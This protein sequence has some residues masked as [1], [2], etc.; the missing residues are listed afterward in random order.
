MSQRILEDVRAAWCD[1]FGSAPDE[2]ERDFFDCGGNSLLAIRLQ[3]A[4]LTRTGAALTVAELLRH[5]TIGAQAAYIGSTGPVGSGP[6]SGSGPRA[7]ESGRA[8]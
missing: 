1:V 8:D 5:R 3:R 2:P 4:L 7:D 6:D